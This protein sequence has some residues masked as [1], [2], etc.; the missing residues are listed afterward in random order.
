[1]LI[2]SLDAYKNS[3]DDPIILSEISFLLLNHEFGIRIIGVTIRIS[4]TIFVRYLSSF[5]YEVSRVFRKEI[6]VYL[7]HFV[8]NLRVISLV[9]RIGP[10][11]RAD[12]ISR[13][14]IR[15]SGDGLGFCGPEK[16]REVGNEE[17]SEYNEQ[18]DIFEGVW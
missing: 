6:E 16:G 17:Y 8:Y 12:G 13:A 15:S 3:H 5:V 10:V 1:M 7:S 2:N 4:Y 11:C 9:F 18:Y 14:L